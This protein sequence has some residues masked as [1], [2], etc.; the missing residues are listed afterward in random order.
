MGLQRCCI[1]YFTCQNN[2]SKNILHE[3]NKDTFKPRHD[4]DIFYFH[5]SDYEPDQQIRFNEYNKTLDKKFLLSHIFQ[6]I[7][8]S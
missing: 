2:S 1:S 5:K 3:N 4:M 6:L 7:I 8:H